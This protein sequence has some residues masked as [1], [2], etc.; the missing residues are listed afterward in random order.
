MCATGHY[1]TSPCPFL[2]AIDCLLLTGH[3]RYKLCASIKHL[4]VL[5][6]LTGKVEKNVL[7]S[8]LC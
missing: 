1:G 3:K 7:T 6:L 4:R 2:C 5:A 8:N